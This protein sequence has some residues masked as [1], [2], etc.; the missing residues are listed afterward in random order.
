[1]WLSKYNL[2]KVFE[3][4]S[5]IVLFVIL[6]KVIVFVAV[7]WVCAQDL[8]ITSG[9]RL[10]LSCAYMLLLI[11]LYRFTNLMA[12]VALFAVEKAFPTI[13]YDTAILFYK[14]AAQLNK[15]S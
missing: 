10:L 12:A 2:V 15:S 9:W 6:K 13:S 3:R 8:C 1:M 5:D 7:C 14:S 11:K 4:L